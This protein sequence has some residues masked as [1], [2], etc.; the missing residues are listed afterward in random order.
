M[1]S[2]YR[3]TSQRIFLC[4]YCSSSFGA[5]RGVKA[6]ISSTKT[7]RD[8]D[9]KANAVAA[10][11][12]SPSPPK[13]MNS[14]HNRKK[15]L[16]DHVHTQEE[17]NF[18]VDDRFSPQ[19]TNKRPRY[20]VTV[21]DDED[22]KDDDASGTQKSTGYKVEEYPLKVASIQGQEPL[23]F[24]SHRKAQIKSG[25]EPWFPF[26][27]R[28]E[29]ELAEWLTTSGVSQ[30]D[31]D[32]YLKLKITRERTIPSFKNNYALQKMM[33]TLPTGPKFKCKVFHAIGDLTD[34]D[35]KPLT[36]ELELWYRDPLEVIR[37]I[38]S[39]VMLA[40]KMHYKPVKVFDA[41]GSV[42]F[43]DEMWTAAWWWDVQVRGFKPM[44]DAML[45]YITQDKLKE[46]A[47]VIPVI[48]SSDKTKLSV[49]SGDKVAWPVYLTIGNVP[50][51]IRR[52]PSMHAT[53]L[54][55]YIPTS[56]LECFSA[57]RRAEEGYKLFHLCMNHI[58]APLKE[59]G[60]H[61][62]GC[63]LQGEPMCAMSSTAG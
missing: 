56:K 48:L 29:W 49:F 5:Q 47:T 24:P 51:G 40:D 8:E 28:Q 4:P 27:D 3:N 53:I 7:C 46:G 34:E 17:F 42:R 36:E 61:V 45:R 21:E 31:I 63:M 33:D 35:D 58:L 6:H 12:R 41:S 44:N 23:P 55:G 16:N 32:K 13:G 1:S 57:N 54:L 19:P 62:F 50:K 11:N 25:Q 38:M 9:F 30:T 10:A 14:S 26:A 37:E 39:N 59:A 52:R 43:Y 20:Q 18:N 22:D 15:A 60:Q 2:R